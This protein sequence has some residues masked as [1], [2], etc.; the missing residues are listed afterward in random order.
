MRASNNA[1]KM[2][3][4]LDILA[5]FLGFVGLFLIFA[6]GVSNPCNIGGMACGVAAIIL[7]LTTTW[8]NKGKNVKGDEKSQ[9]RDM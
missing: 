9:L 5:C 7:F 6:P 3:L 8:N 1:S 4:T 2:R